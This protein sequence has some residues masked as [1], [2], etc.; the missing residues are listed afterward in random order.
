MVTGGELR[1]TEGVATALEAEG[2][3]KE[4]EAREGGVAAAVEAGA[5]QPAR[6]AALAAVVVK[7]RAEGETVAAAVALAMEVAAL[8]MVVA[9]TAVGGRAAVRTEEE[10]ATE[11]AGMAM[12]AAKVAASVRGAVWVALVKAGMLPLRQCSQW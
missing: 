4:A 10:R 5:R 3:E 7:E 11:E 8:G 9:A 1:V 6:L 12:V 2:M